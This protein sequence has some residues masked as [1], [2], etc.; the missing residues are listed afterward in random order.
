M[1][2]DGESV[3]YGLILPLITRRAGRLG[4]ARFPT[5]AA[6]SLMRASSP[7]GELM[8]RSANLDENYESHPDP[9]DREAVAALA[10]EYHGLRAEIRKV[11]VGQDDVIEQLFI[12]L[13]ARGHV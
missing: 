13:F 12:G 4:A 9:D 3:G 7:F 1:P 10:E 6:R 11:I 5:P 2:P 8:F